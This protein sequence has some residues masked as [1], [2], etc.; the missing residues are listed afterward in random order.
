[1]T[2]PART[3]EHDPVMD[4]LENDIDEMNVKEANEDVEDD[5]E[6]DDEHA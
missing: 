3:G 6:P 1:M 2:H 5:P 4:D